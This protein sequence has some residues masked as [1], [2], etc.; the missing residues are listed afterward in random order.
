MAPRKATKVTQKKAPP[1]TP[2]KAAGYQYYSN[3]TDFDAARAAQQARIEANNPTLPTAPTAPTAARTDQ[4]GEGYSLRGGKVSKA[5][6]TRKGV[7]AVGNDDDGGQDE[8]GDGDGGGVNMAKGKGKEKDKPTNLS[9]TKG[10][11]KAT[12]KPDASAASSSRNNGGNCG[13]GAGSTRA[14]NSGGVGG[15][16]ARYNYTEISWGELF[17]AQNADPHATGIRV[18]MSW[19]TYR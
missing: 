12:S 3:D 14:D 10:N 9:K 15:V 17:Q 5:R 4:D 13:A 16:G 1:K 18:G 2:P 7:P 6:G 19:D 8:D 11:S